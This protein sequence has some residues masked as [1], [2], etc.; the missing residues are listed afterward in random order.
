MLGKC[1]G[2]N[3]GRRGRLFGQL[4]ELTKLLLRLPQLPSAGTLID[5]TLRKF[6]T[7]LVRPRDRPKLLVELLN[8]GAIMLLILISLGANLDP[9]LKAKQKENG[10]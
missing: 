3:N 6:K 10:N 1:G 2:E 8:L 9:F 7:K 4:A 5:R